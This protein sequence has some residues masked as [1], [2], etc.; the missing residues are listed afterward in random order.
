LSGE[1]RRFLD[2]VR[3][4]SAIRRGQPV[5]QRR[6]FFEGSAVPGTGAKDIAWLTPFGDEMTD[7]DWH[8]PEA[9]S[10]GVMLAG[11]ALDEL[12][13]TG[14]PV[15]GDTLLLLL[16]ADTEAVSFVL[17][18]YTTRGHWNLLLDTVHEAGTPDRRGLW[19]PETDYLVGGISLCLFRWHGDGKRT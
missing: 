4:V 14:R 12:D 3:R 18:G 19:R 8:D 5:L 11:E 16:N 17:P 1:Q 2:F 6:S 7:Q 13:S 15:L 10:L 9:R